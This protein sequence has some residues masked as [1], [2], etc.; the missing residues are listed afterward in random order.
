MA[1]F[2]VPAINLIGIG[3]IKELGSNV[4]EL[5]YKKALFVTDNLL[6]KSEMIDVVL[7]ELDN[8]AIDYVIYADVDPNPTCKNVNEGVAMALA[9]NCDFII[10][11]G[12][13]S[14][15]DAASAI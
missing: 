5:G 1:T 9:E 8:A 4:K 6:A 10:S 3:C 13:G 14:P 15:Q 2:Y 11:F 12:G 7:A